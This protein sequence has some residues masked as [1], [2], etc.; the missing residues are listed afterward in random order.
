[1]NINNII[2]FMKST[3]IVLIVSAIGALGAYIFNINYWATFCLLFVFQYIIFS[4]AGNIITNYFA[5][6]TRQKELDK[7]ENLSTILEC[8]YCN[9]KNLMI[10]SPHQEE[11]IEFECN[12]CKN[13][14]IVNIHFVVA[15]VT[16]T[17]NMAN[18]TGIP[19]LN[20]EN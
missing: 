3:V 6:K 20:D 5:E 9:R 19:L 4:F 7:L 1:M 15:R 16:D 11:R 12:S 14:N 2:D 13:K 18:V 8:A 10:F 17:I